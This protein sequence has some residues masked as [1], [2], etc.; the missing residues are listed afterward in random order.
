MLLTA[1][2]GQT[3]FKTTRIDVETGEYISCT[4]LFTRGVFL[5]FFLRQPIIHIATIS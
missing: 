2:K 3:R 5:N 1:K 4:G